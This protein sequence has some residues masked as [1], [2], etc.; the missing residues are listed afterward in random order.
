MFSCSGVRGIIRKG[1]RRAE[2]EEVRKSRSRTWLAHTYASLW[3]DKL[4]RGVVHRMLFP[5]T[6]VAVKPVGNGS[7][8][9]SDIISM[10]VR[11]DAA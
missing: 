11:K 5:S 4:W 1:A 10:R 2:E 9:E 6:C 3:D 8:R 7:M